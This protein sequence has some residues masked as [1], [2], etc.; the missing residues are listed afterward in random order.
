MLLKHLECAK[1]A[2]NLNVPKSK[3]SKKSIIIVFKSNFSCAEVL[4]VMHTFNYKNK[5][6]RLLAH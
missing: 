3:Y 1:M 2:A 6:F 5:K 4:A